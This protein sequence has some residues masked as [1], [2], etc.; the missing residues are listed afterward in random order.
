MAIDSQRRRWL[1]GS[2]A[3]AGLAM[4][5]PLAQAAGARPILIGL[6]AEFRD[7]TS[8]SDDAIRLGQLLQLAGQRLWINVLD[9][10]DV[11]DGR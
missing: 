9:R 3:L 6:D 10:L 1:T 11:Q 2:A 4:V 8:T 7:R 5:P